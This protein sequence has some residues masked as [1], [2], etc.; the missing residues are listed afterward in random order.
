MSFTQRL[1]H[2]TQTVYYATR[3]KDLIIINLSQVCRKAQQQ[4]PKGH[5]C[6]RFE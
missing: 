2:R 4:N 5:T 6:R 1:T 3:I